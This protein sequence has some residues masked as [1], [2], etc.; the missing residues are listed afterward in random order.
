MLVIIRFQLLFNFLTKQIHIPIINILSSWMFRFNC[1]RKFLRPEVPRARMVVVWRWTR[2][3]GSPPSSPCTVGGCARRHLV[4]TACTRAFRYIPL[5]Y[6]FS[7]DQDNRT[8]NRLRRNAP[9]SEAFFDR[10]AKPSLVSSLSSIGLA[11]QP[12]YRTGVLYSPKT[13]A[14]RAFTKYHLVG[15]ASVEVFLTVVR[16][17]EVSL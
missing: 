10:L 6:L 1:N 4:R 7:D 8:K 5:R 11:L 13:C 12:D 2:A 17:D 3:K 14:K 9:V 15:F 16:R